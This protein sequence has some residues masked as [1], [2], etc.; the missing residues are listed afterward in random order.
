MDAPAPTCLLPLRFKL[1]SEE[2]FPTCRG[3]PIEKVGMESLF[4]WSLMVLSGVDIFLG[5][6]SK[7]SIFG[8][9][10][11]ELAC[12]VDQLGLINLGSHDIDFLH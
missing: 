7:L 6:Y 3:D 2:L 10:K 4:R 1:G 9:P 5:M 12:K 11:D 8:T